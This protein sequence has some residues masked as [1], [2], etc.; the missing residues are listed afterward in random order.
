MTHLEI[1]LLFLSSLLTA[2]LWLY[3]KENESI[4]EELDAY[5]TYYGL[6]LPEDLKRGVR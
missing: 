5:I 2:L 6:Y 3:E 4:K 1:A